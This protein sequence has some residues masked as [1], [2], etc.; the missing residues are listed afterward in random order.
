MG[1]WELFGLVVISK[2]K[3]VNVLRS[4]SPHVSTFNRKM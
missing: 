4:L 2:D 1:D 3:D